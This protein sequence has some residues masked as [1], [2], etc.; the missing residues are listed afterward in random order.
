[1]LQFGRFFFHFS[2]ACFDGFQFLKSDIFGKN[3][4][5]YKSFLRLTGSSLVSSDKSGSLSSSRMLV[6]PG[7]ASIDEVAIFV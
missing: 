1:L 6:S 3:V 7:L 2:H 5:Q 4:D